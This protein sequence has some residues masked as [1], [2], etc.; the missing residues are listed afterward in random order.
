VPTRSTRGGA[1]LPDLRR[2]AIGCNLARPGDNAPSR[3]GRQKDHE[4]GS[5][6]GEREAVGCGPDDHTGE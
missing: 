2:G 3:D 1:Q 5:E 4:R 6:F